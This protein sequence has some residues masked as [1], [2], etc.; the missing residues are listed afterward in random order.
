MNNKI[1]TESFVTPSP[2]MVPPPVENMLAHRDYVTQ[3]DAPA[4]HARLSG[5]P[6]TGVY[7]LTLN[8]VDLIT[9]EFDPAISSRRH[10]SSIF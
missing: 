2:A 9:L 7:H 10:S 8:G 1:E 3:P 6:N 4:T 5:N